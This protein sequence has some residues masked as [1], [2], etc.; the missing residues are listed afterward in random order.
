[1]DIN[2]LMQNLTI[3]LE[4]RSSYNI[5]YYLKRKKTKN[6]Q[7]IKYKSKKQNVKEKKKTE[8]EKKG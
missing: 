3:L 2:Y 1:M 6:K 7:N 5:V 4:I 8:I